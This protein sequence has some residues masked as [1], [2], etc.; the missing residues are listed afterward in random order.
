MIAETGASFYPGYPV[1]DGDVEVKRNWWRQFWSAETRALYPLLK[2]FIFFSSSS[3][4]DPTAGP[5]SG[6]SA[7][8]H[9]SCVGVFIVGLLSVGLFAV[10][11]FFSWLSIKLA[12]G[13]FSA[14][15]YHID[16]A[17]RQWSTL[18]I[19]SQL[20]TQAKS[21]TTQFPKI[22]QSLQLS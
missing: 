16:D 1:G 5:T 10:G 18:N 14:C 3:P 19:S 6:L 21:G 7:M 20:K 13:F 15:I 2:V 11:G 8:P 12:D 4:T 17:S 9:V 22:H